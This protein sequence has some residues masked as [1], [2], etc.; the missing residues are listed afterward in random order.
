MVLGIIGAVLEDTM[1]KN[2]ITGASLLQM[3]HPEGW[4]LNQCILDAGV[5]VCAP[6]EVLLMFK[7]SG[8]WGE[9]V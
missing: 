3:L 8:L 9:R 1:S 2:D 5:A 6:A 4:T 7:S